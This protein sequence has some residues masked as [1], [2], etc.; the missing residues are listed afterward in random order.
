MGKQRRM[1]KDFYRTQML[2]ETSMGGSIKYN[3]YFSKCLYLIG[4]ALSYKNRTTYKHLCLVQCQ[5]AITL[6]HETNKVGM[7]KQGTSYTK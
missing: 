7:S 6:K 5:N 3:K 2:V 1:E 4:V